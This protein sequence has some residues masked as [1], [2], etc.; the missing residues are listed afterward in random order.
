MT[1][2]HFPCTRHEG[3]WERG[4]IAPLIT[5]FGLDGGDCSAYV[6]GRLTLRKQPP[7]LIL[8]YLLSAVVLTPGGSSTVH[9]YT[10]KY[11]EK[12]NYRLWLE[13]FL[14]FEHRVVKLKLTMN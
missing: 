7:I 3:M 10:Q 2:L 4:G 6:F 12:H 14:G 1:S 5:Y 13:G 11:I 9:I 8:I